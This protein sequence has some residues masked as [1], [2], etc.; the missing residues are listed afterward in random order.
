MAPGILLDDS[1]AGAPDVQST[2]I[3]NNNA[4]RAIFPDGIRTSGQHA[5][6]YSLLRSYEEFPRDITD[7]TVWKAEDYQDHFVRWVHRFTEDE[8]AELG[9][10]ADEF[11]ASGL[12]LT[13]MTKENF[14]LPR[15]SPLMDDIREDVIKGNGFHLTKGFPV[16]E[17]GMNKSAVAY[18]GLGTYLGYF[19]S[20]N[21]NGHILGHVQVNES[22]GLLFLVVADL[23]R[24][25]TG[26][27][28]R[29]NAHPS[30][31]DLP[32]KCTAVL[33][34]GHQ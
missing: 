28:R 20:Q 31:P 17:W 8:T 21:G 4:P 14:K 16:E 32:R 34:R 9:A 7:Q 22:L 5:P 13:G 24:R 12:P 6:I 2:K 33:P 30:R 3:S 15:L 18:I 25:Y 29:S 26:L 11:I 23:F 1:N 27:G 10:V 19:V